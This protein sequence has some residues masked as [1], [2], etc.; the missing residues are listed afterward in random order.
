MSEAITIT[1]PISHALNKF[2]ASDV[3]ENGADKNVTGYVRYL[4]QGGRKCAKY[5]S[6]DRLQ[7]G[8]N[9]SSG[10]SALHEMRA[11]K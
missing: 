11:I 3:G 2:V 9:G 1:L 7:S 5:E 6:F 10:A 8:W 4:I